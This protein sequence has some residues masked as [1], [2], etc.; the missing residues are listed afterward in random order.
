MIEH[1]L[2]GQTSL[3]RA[4]PTAVSLLLM[5]SISFVEVRAGTGPLRRTAQ[6][7]DFDVAATIHAADRRSPQLV[8]TLTNRRDMEIRVTPAT[9]SRGNVIIVLAEADSGAILK[10]QR[11]PEGLPGGTLIVP[12]RGSVN[13]EVDLASRF[14]ELPTALESGPVIVFWAFPVFLYRD[15]ERGPR[16]GGLLVIN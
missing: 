11:F 14:P 6:A 13:A 2:C 8:F 3:N 5:V 15:E 12:P 4:I 9:L 1:R 16:A 7:E 10:E